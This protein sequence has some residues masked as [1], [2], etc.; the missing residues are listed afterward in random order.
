MSLIKGMANI[1]PPPELWSG[2][3][4]QDAGK[5]GTHRNFIMKFDEKV[6]DLW[7]DYR[8]VMTG[9]DVTLEVTRAAAAPSLRDDSEIKIASGLRFRGLVDADGRR[10]C[11]ARFLRFGIQSQDVQGQKS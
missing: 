8:N 11:P 6:Q 9:G 2:D 5:A 4:T 1:N 3:F 10:G 7:R